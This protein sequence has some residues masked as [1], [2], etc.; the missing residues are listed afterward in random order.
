VPNNYL[1]SSKV[2]SR[3]FLRFCGRVAWVG[4]GFFVCARWPFSFWA[5][6]V[7][8]GG[9][10]CGG[11]WAG[12]GGGGWGGGEGGGWE[13]GLVWKGGVGEAPGE[14]GGGRVLPG[15]KTE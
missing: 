12:G 10:G 3:L 6:V 11:V 4:F 14:E 13:G 8:G 1:F 5:A 9:L 2:L 15:T 7:G